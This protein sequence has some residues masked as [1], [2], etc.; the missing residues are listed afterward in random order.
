MSA[1]NSSGCWTELWRGGLG[2]DA[3]ASGQEAAEKQRRRLISDTLG[4][5]GRSER[6]FGVDQPEEHSS[7][8]IFHHESPAE[9]KRSPAAH[10]PNEA[11][12]L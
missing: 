1:V 7:S 2:P 3:R 6:G 12:S 8:L 10:N 4:A 11:S 9:L 5:N